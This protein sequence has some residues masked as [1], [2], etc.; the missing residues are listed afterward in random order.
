[1]EKTTPHVSF[2]VSL[3]ALDCPL[4]SVVAPGKRDSEFNR[5]K[6]YLE[7]HYNMKIYKEVEQ[8]YRVKDFERP[9]YCSTTR[10][11][12]PLMFSIL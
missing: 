8:P 4:V 12:I 7:N 5:G 6:T 3:Q 2:L 10:K 11:S 1:M 9:L